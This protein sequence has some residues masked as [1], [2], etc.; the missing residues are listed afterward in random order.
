MENKETTTFAHDGI[1]ASTSGASL[2]DLGLEV[3][4]NNEAQIVVERPVRH[5]HLSEMI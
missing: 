3:V 5:I 2:A 1:E 4:N